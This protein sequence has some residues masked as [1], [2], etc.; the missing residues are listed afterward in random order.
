M[1]P[2][3]FIHLFLDMIPLLQQLSIPWAKFIDDRLETTPKIFGVNTG[4]W[5]N[6]VG[7]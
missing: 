7:L 1:T 4:S 5:Q 3:P 6:L 2:V